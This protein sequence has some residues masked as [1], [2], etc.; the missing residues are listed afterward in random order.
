MGN[1]F[2]EEWTRAVANE[3]DFVPVFIGWWEIPEYRMPIS[4]EFH[5]EPEEKELK[6]AL[7]LSN[8]Q[9]QWRRYVLFTQC[10]GSEDYFNQEYPLS[11]GVAFLTTGR[12]AFNTKVLQEMYDLAMKFTPERGEMHEAGFSP[13]R[14]RQGNFTVY[15]RPESGHDYT[16]GADPSAGVEGGDPAAIQVMDRTRMEQVAVWHGLAEPIRFAQVIN[17]VGRWYNNAMIAPELNGGWGFSVV[18]ELTKGYQYPRI[19]IWQRVDKVKRSISNYYGWWTT[20]STRP[21][22]IDSTNFAINEKELLLRDA[23]TIKELLEFQYF[24]GRRAEGLRH[25]DLAM[26]WMIAYRLHLETPLE[27]TGLP[28][29]VR[30]T[31]DTAAKVEIPTYTRG[32]D[33][34]AW[35]GADQALEGMKKQVQSAASEWDSPDQEPGEAAGFVPDWPW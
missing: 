34:D 1:A 31:D 7:G 3:S 5:L 9:I 27:S 10:R 2:H 13:N 24:D 11:P 20:N 18:E 15:R 14:H 26:A 4:A 28:P 32:I 6:K 29:R 22:L 21:L 33:K 30:F 23:A 17:H 8:E 12:P 16:I 35:E 19:Y 25:D